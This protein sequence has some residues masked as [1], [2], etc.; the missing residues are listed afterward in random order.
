MRLNSLL[1]LQMLYLLFAVG[2]NVVAIIHAT[3]NDAATPL[4]SYLSNFGGLFVFLLILVLGRFRQIRI[5]RLLM[6]LYGIGCTY[7]GIVP[8]FI[9][10]FKLESTFQL[11]PIVSG[12]GI[13]IFG[14]SLCMIAALG[15]FHLE[16]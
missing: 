15:R 1:K 11:I 9:K 10:L 5:Y 12:A 6:A 2:W 3:I 16:S 8:W 14:V 13:N 7:V 4:A